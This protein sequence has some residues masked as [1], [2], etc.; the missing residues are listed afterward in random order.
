MR[1][2]LDSRATPGFVEVQRFRQWW[3]LAVLAAVS[4][5][6]WVFFIVQVVLGQPIGSRPAPDWLMVALVLVI[7]LGLPTLFLV[8]R[9]ETRVDGE[10]LVV[11]FVPLAR[12]TFALAEVARASAETYHPLLDYGGWGIRYGWRGWCYNVSGNRGVRLTLK[13]GREVMLGSQRPEELVT[14]IEAAAT[15]ADPT[16]RA[17][18]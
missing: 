18:T 8:M 15:A 5:S 12:R 3:L 1:P 9:M 6:T 13:D 7:G 10:S 16:G 14:A 2:A 11:R 4:G 17:G